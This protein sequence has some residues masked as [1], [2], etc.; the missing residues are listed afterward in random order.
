MTGKQPVFCDRCSAGTAVSSPLFLRFPPLL[1]ITAVEVFKALKKEENQR[2]RSNLTGVTF[3]RRN[4]GKSG[5]MMT[6]TR[7]A[8]VIGQSARQAGHKARLSIIPLV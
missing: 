3:F 1:W 7:M 4:S 2:P 8:A 5:P 6:A